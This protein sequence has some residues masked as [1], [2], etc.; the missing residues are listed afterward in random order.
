[1]GIAQQCWVDSFTHP[2]G[3]PIAM[4]GAWLNST[5]LLGARARLKELGLTQ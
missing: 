1:M 3:I 4:L 2:F 5:W